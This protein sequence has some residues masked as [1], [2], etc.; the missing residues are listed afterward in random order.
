[1]T[2]DCFTVPLPDCARPLQVVAGAYH[3]AV[4]TGEHSRKLTRVGAFLSSDFVF[5]YLYVSPILQW[6][7]MKLDLYFDIVLGS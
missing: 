1:M 7:L 6:I 4:R 3:S 2:F 5:S